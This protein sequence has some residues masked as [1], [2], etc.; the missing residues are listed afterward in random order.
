MF[1]DDPKVML[2]CMASA[3]CEQVLNSFGDIKNGQHYL[4]NELDKIYI[5]KQNSENILVIRLIFLESLYKI[6][7]LSLKENAKGTL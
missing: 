3:L 2:Q 6:K 5:F 1:G 7:A 4:V